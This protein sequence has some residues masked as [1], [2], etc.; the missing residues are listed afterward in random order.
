MRFY[1]VKAKFFLLKEKLYGLLVILV[2]PEEKLVESA[3]GV[4]SIFSETHQISIE[5][6]WRE[7]E[8]YIHKLR[9]EGQYTP[10]VTYDLQN[11]LKNLSVHPSMVEEFCEKLLQ[12]DVAGIKE[13]LK[14]LISS[15]FGN[16]DLNIEIH[17][18][19]LSEEDLGREISS[20]IEEEGKGEE[21]ISSEKTLLEVTPILDPIKGKPI[22]DLRVGEKI[23][24]R[25]IPN[26]PKANYFID[27][28]GLREEGKIKPVEA[29]I[30][31]IEKNSQESNILVEITQDLQ[32][33]FSEENKVKVRLYT[34]SSS[35]EEGKS[36]SGVSLAGITS[37]TKKGGGSLSMLVIGGATILLGLLLA[38]LLL[39]S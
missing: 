17:I 35:S 38:Y 31:S 10:N 7:V 36:A 32:G 30:L 11:A 22:M 23:M 15:A 37:S 25:L 8:D 5:T 24:V 26:T 21:V 3:T 6:P 20:S 34:G 18:E 29:K 1:A 16:E 2:K 14:D 19:E 12:K 28:L 13:K 4:V 27:L 39:I 9:Y 33:K